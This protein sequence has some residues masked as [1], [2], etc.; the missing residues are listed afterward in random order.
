MSPKTSRPVR[1]STSGSVKVRSQ[2]GKP[3]LTEKIRPDVMLCP[4]SNQKSSNK[5]DYER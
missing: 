1:V 4:T 5:P 3:N 2:M